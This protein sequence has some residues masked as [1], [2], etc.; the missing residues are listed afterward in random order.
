[1]N[2]LRSAIFFCLAFSAS[3]A[4][5]WDPAASVDELPPI[6][7]L[8]FAAGQ[9]EGSYYE[10]ASRLR[11]QVGENMLDHRLML[12]TRTTTGSVD[13]GLEI[14]FG[15]S[16]LGIM[17][18]DVFEDM[19]AGKPPAPAG[20]PL[21]LSALFV[22]DDE[23]FV[24]IARA[25]SKI[26]GM[27]DLSRS[28]IGIGAKG[29]GARITALKV[30][31]ASGLPAETLQLD[32]VSGISRRTDLF[33]RGKLDAVSF[34]ISLP[35]PSISR[36]LGDCGG[37]L[38]GLDVQTLQRLTGDT[39]AYENAPAPEG[40]PIRGGDMLKVKSVVVTSDLPDQQIRQL[41]EVVF[42]PPELQKLRRLRLSSGASQATASPIGLPTHPVAEAFFNE[43]TQAALQSE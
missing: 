34:V 8:R 1:M 11:S 9:P 37:T 2:F 30:L 21:P 15:T 33:C 36:L 22:A 38:V 25:G 23:F 32:E 4:G 28:K 29:S 19:I 16:D 41:L 27:R 13:N 17:Q 14:A 3:H 42:D 5:P 7:T 39:A 31:A 43:I 35:N 10:Q 6:T 26:S 18:A 40:H 20:A 12:S 24:L